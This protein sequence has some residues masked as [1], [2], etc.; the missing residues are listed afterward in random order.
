MVAIR[1]DDERDGIRAKIL[2]V[3]AGGG[4]GNAVN[5]MISGGLQG[6]EFV[7]MNT[8]MQALEMSRANHRVQLGKDRT[9]GLGAGA[10]PTIGRESALED[11]NHITELV[12]DYDMV[13]VTA[14]MGGG[15]GTG[16]APVIADAARAA[17]A[18]TVGVVTK[19]FFF[20]GLPRARNADQGI[21]E[22]RRHVDALVVIPNDRLTEI[23]NEPMGLLEAFALADGVLSDAVRSISDLIVVQGLVNV[24]FADAKR[25]MQGKGKAIMGMGEGTGEGRAAQAAQ[26]AMTSSL[27]E[28]TSIDGATGVLVNITGG[29]DLKIQEIN[30]AMGL[31]QK[32]ADDAAEIIMGCV[33]DQEMTDRIKLTIIATGF[34][35]D[36]EYGKDLSQQMMSEMPVETA[37]P[38]NHW[39]QQ[40]QR[41]SGILAG[42]ANRGYQQQAQPVRQAGMLGDKGRAYGAQASPPPLPRQDVVAVP[43]RAPA[44][45]QPAEE[46]PAADKEKDFDPSKTNTWY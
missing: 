17:G 18:L 19:P 34:D 3:G 27:L 10:D 5:N 13:F 20:E 7:A 41:P 33:I 22:L 16:S 46:T 26:R 32:S 8:D 11:K 44:T 23:C 45:A 40:Q 25:I 29:P 2:V 39:Q 4:G 15:T 24:D 31:I 38:G 42:G 28:E 14:G 35:V 36:K 21:A 37:A 9:R 6:V 12:K 30:E 1:M 43:Q